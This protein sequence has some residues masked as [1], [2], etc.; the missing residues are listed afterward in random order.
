MLSFYCNNAILGWNSILQFHSELVKLKNVWTGFLFVVINDEHD[1]TRQFYS[2]FQ[3]FVFGSVLPVCA[4][5]P[6]NDE[7]CHVHVTLRKHENWWLHTL[8][9]IVSHHLHCFQHTLIFYYEMLIIWQSS[10]IHLFHFHCLYVYQCQRC[11]IE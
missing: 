1:I 2:N 5:F 9:Q 8:Y 11:Q 3:I 7:K 4:K 10:I 6:S